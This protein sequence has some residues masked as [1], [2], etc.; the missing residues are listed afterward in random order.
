MKTQLSQ[1]GLLAYKRT[2]SKCAKHYSNDSESDNATETPVFARQIL[3]T[4]GQCNTASYN[5]IHQY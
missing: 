3:V 5:V 4:S 1:V 2:Y